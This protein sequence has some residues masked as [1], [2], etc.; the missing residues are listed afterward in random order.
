MN[1]PIIGYKGEIVNLAN[2]IQAKP[3]GKFGI[4]LKVI[5]S[6]GAGHREQYRIEHRE[7]FL[8]WPRTAWKELCA[9]AGVITLGEAA[10]G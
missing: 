5:G 1:G 7:V 4:Q 10:E 3:A 8:K 2:V 6:A 9:K